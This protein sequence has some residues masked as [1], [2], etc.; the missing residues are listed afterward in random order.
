MLDMIPGHRRGE[1][2]KKFPKLKSLTLR[3]MRGMYYANVVKVNCRGELSARNPD[4]VHESTLVTLRSSIV[5]DLKL[6]VLVGEDLDGLIDED[7]VASIV[8]DTTDAPD[9]KVERYKDLKFGPGWGFFSSIV[10]IDRGEWENPGDTDLARNLSLV[11]G[12]RCVVCRSSGGGRWE[13]SGLGF[14]PA[15][16]CGGKSKAA[17]AAKKKGSAGGGARRKKARI[18]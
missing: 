7:F 1:S 6:L 14:L 2:A 18:V 15:C 16:V 10:T 4:F 9:V 13:G 8:P 11:R 12:E 5:P 3:L 17:A